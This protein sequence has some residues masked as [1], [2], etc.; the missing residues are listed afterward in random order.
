MVSGEHED[1]SLL[2]ADLVED[3]LFTDAK[4]P[5]GGSQGD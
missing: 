5:A 1:G 4:R 2:V 3:T